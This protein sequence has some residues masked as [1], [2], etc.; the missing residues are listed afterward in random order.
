MKP[1]SSL[2]RLANIFDG[3]KISRANKRPIGTFDIDP[4]QQRLQ[5]PQPP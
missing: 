4:L 5:G 3:E 2:L 1:T